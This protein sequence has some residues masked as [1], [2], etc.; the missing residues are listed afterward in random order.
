[1]SFSFCPL[2]FLPFEL[3]SFPPIILLS[4]PFFLTI[5]FYVSILC[6]SFFVSSLLFPETD[7]LLP[8][9]VVSEGWGKR[10]TT[11]VSKNKDHSKRRIFHGE[12]Q[13][14]STTFWHHTDLIQHVGHGLF[15][16]LNLSGS[17]H[18]EASCRGMGKPCWRVQADLQCLIN[19]ARYSGVQNT[20]IPWTPFIEEVS[21]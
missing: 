2:L 5:A 20:G 13:A 1:M 12:I 15:G 14:I 8:A 7:P 21:L 19:P 6:P 11:A 10:C 9:S 4:L 16:D 18:W 17:T 3:H